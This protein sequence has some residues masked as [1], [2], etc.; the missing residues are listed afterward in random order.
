VVKAILWRS[1]F[2]SFVPS[3]TIL[4]GLRWFGVAAPWTVSARGA[5]GRQ[6]HVSGADEPMIFDS[7]ENDQTRDAS[8]DA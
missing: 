1:R 3:V 7:H 8:R 2:V 6:R 4:M 5:A